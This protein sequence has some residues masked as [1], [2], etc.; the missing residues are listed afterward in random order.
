MPI[1]G[2]RIFGLFQDRYTAIEAARLLRQAGIPRTRLMPARGPAPAGGFL[3]PAD[4]WLSQVP[5]VAMEAAEPLGTW[6]GGPL[7]EWPGSHGDA[8]LDSEWWVIA[9][10]DGS[11]TEIERA[12][13]I[14]KSHGGEM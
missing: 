6:D 10:T 2:Q 1:A 3:S 4:P 14:I 9:D 5:P 13:K 12:V 11:D 8:W 7:S